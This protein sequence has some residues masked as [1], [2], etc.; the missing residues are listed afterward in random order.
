MACERTAMGSHP[1][2]RPGSPRIGLHPWGGEKSGK[3][4]A[5]SWIALRS[6][7]WVRAVL[8]SSYSLG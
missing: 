3:D 6:E 4:G 5:R 1:F 2:R 7:G 8:G